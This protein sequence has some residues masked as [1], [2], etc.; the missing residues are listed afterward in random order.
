MR[1]KMQI[2]AESYYDAAQMVLDF[3][4]YLELE[5]F[6]PKYKRSGGENYEGSFALGSIR[7]IKRS[8]R[9]EDRDNSQPIEY[10]H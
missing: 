2:E 6:K 3:A 10:L 7:V 8:D 1:I 5:R 4:R 9:I